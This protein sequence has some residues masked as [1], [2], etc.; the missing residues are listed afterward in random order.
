MKNRLAALIAATVIGMS[1]MPPAASAE[2][3]EGPPTRSHSHS[4]M[5]CAASGSTTRTPK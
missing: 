3:A 1:L 5:G 2:D 4:P